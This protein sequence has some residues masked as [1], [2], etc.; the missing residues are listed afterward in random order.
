M[1]LDEKELLERDAKR[2][3][4]EEL[5]QAVRDIKAGQVGRI[6][7]V[8]VS[9]L[10]SARQRIGLSQSEFARMLGVSLRTLQE[11][12]QG[13]RKPSGAAKSLIAIAI[14]DPETLQKLLAA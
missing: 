12:E 1:P 5:L 4:G 7:T 3:I 6:S 9:P 8:E 10:A 13:R 2:N 11:W 14:K